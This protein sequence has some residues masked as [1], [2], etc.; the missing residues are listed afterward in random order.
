MKNSRRHWIP[1]GFFVLHMGALIFGLVGILIMLPN[2]DLWSNDPFATDVFTWSMD[3]AGATHIIFGAACMF[4]YGVFAIGWRKTTIFAVTSFVLSLSFELFGTG[5]G[6][7]FGNYEYTGF[8]G[9]KILGLVPYSIPLSWFYMGFA[10]YLLGSL[11]VKRFWQ[12]RSTLWT[13]VGGAFLLLVWDLVLDPA[14]AHESLSIQFW[15][16]DESGPYMGMPTKNFVGWALTGLLF[17]LVSRLLWKEEVETRKISMTI[18]FAIYAANLG[19]AMVL[20]AAVGLW[21]P[22]VLALILGL[23]PAMI[24]I[25]PNNPRSASGSSSDVDSTRLARDA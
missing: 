1:N 22:I 18:P 13:V 16:W 2:P 24:A 19:F 11:L 10:A 7:P 5:T 9:Y 21:V 6:W 14:M 20:S 3:N 12:G 4:A 17:M 8:L 25:L 15:V 23:L